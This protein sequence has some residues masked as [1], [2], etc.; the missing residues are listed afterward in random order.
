MTVKEKEKRTG[1]AIHVQSDTK[2]HFITGST[3]YPYCCPSAYCRWHRIYTPSLHW[4]HHGNAWLRCSWGFRLLHR[5][6]SPPD[7]LH[8]R[9]GTCYA[10]CPPVENRL[11]H[12]V[13]FRFLHIT[14]VEKLC[15]W[16][17]REAVLLTKII[18]KRKSLLIHL[19]DKL[20]FAILQG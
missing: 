7:C 15:I 1:N 16:C 20:Q 18:Q 17:M 3:L 8:S 19:T 10:A 14:N 2:K 9:Y 6:S 11:S 4:R 5:L 12:N 13:W